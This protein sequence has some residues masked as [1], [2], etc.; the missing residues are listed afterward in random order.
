MPMTSA[1]LSQELDEL[2]K[3]LLPL[4]ERKSVPSSKS[5]GSKIASPKSDHETVQALLM[6]RKSVI[7]KDL[8]ERVPV[9]MRQVYRE[10]LM[11]IIGEIG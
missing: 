3:D 8:A 1:Q 6:N 5:T 2:E 4:V 7:T 9:T 11:R 10:G